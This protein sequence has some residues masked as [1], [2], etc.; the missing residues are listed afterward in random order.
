[1]K[2][3]EYNHFSRILILF[4]FLM[5]ISA[6]IGVNAQPQIGMN[7]VS[8]QVSEKAA[9]V[10]DEFIVKFHPSV[11]QKVLLAMD[12][13][14]TTTNV[15]TIDAMNAKYGVLKIERVFKFL[16]SPKANLQL[17]EEIGITRTYL[18]SVPEGTKIEEAVAA[19]ESLAEVEYAEP[20]FIDHVD[21]VPDDPTYPS[22][23]GLNNTGQAIPVGGGGTVGT[24]GADI[25]AEA[26]WDLHTGSSSIILAILDTGVDY[27]HPEF[28]GR[29]VAGI[30]IGDGDN[31]PMDSNGHGTSCAGIAAAT[32]NNGAGVAGVN[33]NCLIMPVKIGVGSAKSFTHADGAAGMVW[34]ANNGA[35]VLSCSYG[36]SDSQTK[37]DGVDYAYAAGCI[38]L[39]SRGNDNVSTAKYPASY[40]N[41][42]AI[43]A[44]SPCND[45]KTP[46]TCDGETNWGSS[47]GSDLDVM[48]P[49]VRIHT[50]D[51]QGS[52]GYT[53]G[54]YTSTF[55]GT[56]A[57]CPFAAGVAALIDS[58]VPG[59]SAAQIRES[60]RNSAVD[61]GDPGFDNQTGYGR[62]NAFGALNYAAS[63]VNDP[64]NAVC[65]DV[66]VSANGN[67]QAAVSPQDVDNGSSDPDGDPLSYELSPEGPYPL[68]ETEVTLTVS[69]DYF[70]STCEATITV[71][72]DTDP[73][74]TCPV[75]ITVDNDEGLCSAVVY[76]SI[77]ATDNCDGNVD[78]VATPAS[79]SVFPVGT[80]VVDV[81]A[82]DD[83]GN[84][85]EC[86][87]SVTVEDNEASVLTCPAE[88]I[89]ENDPGL[90]SAVVEFEISAT[91]NCD[92]DVDIFVDIPSGSV[93][94]VGSTLVSATA[95]DDEG[96]Q[97]DCSFYVTVNDTE[98]PIIEAISDPVVLWPPNS[99]YVSFSLDD[100]ILSVSDNCT[101]L[102]IGDINIPMATSDEPEDVKGGGDGHTSDDIV[103]AGGCKTVEVRVE[104]QGKS[105][106]RVYTIHFE[107][108]DEYNNVGTDSAKI[109]VPKAM[110][111]PVI[112]DGVAYTVSGNC[113]S[114]SG[115]I[116]QTWLQ[117]DLQNEMVAYPNPFTQSTTIRFSVAATDAAVITVYN[118][119]GKEVAEVFSGLVEKGSEYQIQFDGS[120]LP[121]GVYFY[122][123]KVGNEVYLM[124][125]LILMK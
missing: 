101:D 7:Q 75:D 14:R 72:D 49:G 80:T 112:E 114:K 10:A 56:S 92:D 24:V 87:F 46:S 117:H 93:F 50:T 6:F 62:L 20:N 90:C 65:Q 73:V 82:T 86:S 25:N 79:G 104:R 44:L 69:D 94:P 91:D 64:P 21:F 118:S 11:A 77:S 12:E 99:K 27:D 3:E 13:G 63:L 68:G 123:L 98:A 36:G 106:G 9:Y 76:F 43:G 120:K 74:V 60:M 2:Q 30:D 100:L 88:V 35:D 58:Y 8:D 39:S 113:G 32:G 42:V 110:N 31:D 78:I 16:D 66:I 19:Y 84:Q 122:N 40:S 61:L 103:I 102:E 52:G 26:A 28:A 23:W 81:V 121:E 108:A 54:D 111:K 83:A 37:Q 109:F 107:V 15:P 34:A 47:F 70:S 95:T 18:L 105:N 59:L 17:A 67:C 53:S 38:I 1:M 85:D 29:T 45:R 55:N 48:A 71:V 51:I 4:V 22:Q 96:N 41:V 33:W 57:A 124:D 89:A 125:K 5:C 119:M 115:V 116:S 97:S